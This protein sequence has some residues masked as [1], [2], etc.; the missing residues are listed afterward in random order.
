MPTYDR[1]CLTD[2]EAR[3]SLG[4]ARVDLR[5]ATPFARASVRIF[6][7]EQ[8]GVLVVR[9]RDQT[10][11][12]VAQTI[13]LERWGSRRILHWY[14]KIRRDVPRS[15]LDTGAGCDRE[16]LWIRQRLRDLHF[17]VALR[18]EGTGDPRRLHRRAVVFASPAMTEMEATAYLAVVTSEEASDPLAAAIKRVDRAAERGS[19]ALEVEHRRSWRRFWEASFVDLP[20]EQDYLENHW[21][22]ASYHTHSCAQGRY[23]PNHIDALWAWNRDVRPWAHYYHWNEQ[24]HVWPLHAT[25][26]PELAMPYYRWR[27][28][29]LDHAIEDARRVHGRSGAFYSD[30]SNRRGYQ[31]TGPGLREN[32]TPGP[33]IAADFWRHYQYTSDRAFLKEMA[34]PVIREVTRFYLDT[35]VPGAHGR[36]TF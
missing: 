33:Q 11:E 25:G 2:F 19:D 8:A 1:L 4:D 36:F 15:L 7:S 6:A 32:L 29:M 16:H 26:H 35:V 24:I 20:D 30:V 18:C 9:Y 14:R 17:A 10:E 23:P 13:A 3:L 5:A 21:Y 34:Y 31:D 22:L 28:A 27:R 12:P